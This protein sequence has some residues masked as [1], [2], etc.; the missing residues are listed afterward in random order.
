METLKEKITPEPLNKSYI[1]FPSSEDGKTK[2]FKVKTEDMNIIQL[3]VTEQALKMYLE[4]RY[5]Y[6]FGG[7]H[8]ST[9]KTNFCS[10]VTLSN[11]KKL[12]AP[13]RL[14]GKLSYESNPEFYDNLNW[15]QNKF[16][17]GLDCSGFIYACYNL[18]GIK[19]KCSLAKDYVKNKN[20]KIISN[21]QLKAGDVV[22]FPTKNHVI[23]FLGYRN[24][25]EGEKRYFCIHAPS[26]G[27]FLKIG[28]HTMDD[29][30]PLTYCE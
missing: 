22:S 20:F 27:N 2:E 30:V 16:Y 17:Y 24:N 7:G 15:E 25:K 4:R 26:S 19:I 18:A 13:T 9:S 3:K 29:G 28:L 23:I 12:G 14:T 21:D 10:I 11:V 6:I 1:I 8:N 5:I